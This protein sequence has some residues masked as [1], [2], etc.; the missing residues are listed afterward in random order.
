MAANGSSRNGGD[1][2]GKPVGLS[3]SFGGIKA[4]AKV[5]AAGASEAK[6]REIITGIGASGIVAAEGQVAAA[7]PKIIPKQVR[8]AAFMVQMGLVDAAVR[9][10]GHLPEHSAKAHCRRCQKT[11]PIS[12]HI[13]ATAQGVNAA[14]PSFTSAIGTCLPLQEDSFKVGQGPIKQRPQKPKHFLPDHDDGTVGEVG[15]R[16]EAVAEAKA[17]PSIAYGLTLQTKRHAESGAA[18]SDQ[19]G[20]QNNGAAQQN[21][22]SGQNGA[23]PRGPSVTSKEWETKAFKVPSLRSCLIHEIAAW[24]QG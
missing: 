1:A 13:P 19:G 14:T 16:F 10:P 22:R 7:G 18:A 24:L 17:D 12:L 2:N 11:L 20:L 21:G 23:A 3:L 5:S 6:R 9:C 8:I 4:K 15:D